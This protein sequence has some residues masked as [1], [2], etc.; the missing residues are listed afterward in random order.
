MNENST[1][2]E[3]SENGNLIRIDILGLNYP[4]AE[5][6]WD[7]N[8]LKSI[9]SA[10]AGAFSGNFKADLMTTDFETFKNEL[11]NLYDKLKGIATFN[12]LESQVDIKITGDGIGHLKAKCEVMDY[13]GIGNKL[14]FEIDFD[15]TQIPKIVNQLENIITKFPVSGD[16]K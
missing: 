14:E 16:L 9:I 7:R 10:K 6:D 12:T 4:N 8:W 1:Y 15:Q 2:F 3:I 13:A 5:D 11:T